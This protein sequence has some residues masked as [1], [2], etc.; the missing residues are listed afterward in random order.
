MEEHTVSQTKPNSYYSKEKARYELWDNHEWVNP[1]RN[2]LWSIIENMNQGEK[3]GE[4]PKN[5]ST[6]FFMVMGQI[7][8][9]FGFPTK[10]S[11]GNTGG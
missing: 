11:K 1:K 10:C 6:V 5:L 8:L 2:G 9:E 3:G 4:Y 7:M